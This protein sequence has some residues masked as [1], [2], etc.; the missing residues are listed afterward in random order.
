M[1]VVLARVYQAGGVAP[2]TRDHASKVAPVAV[3]VVD[4]VRVEVA[5]DRLAC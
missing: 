4:A 3:K 1:A 5:R 2:K